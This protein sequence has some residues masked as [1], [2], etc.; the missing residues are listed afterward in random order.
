MD[1]ITHPGVF[2]KDRLMAPLGLTPDALAAKLGLPEIDLHYV[3]NGQGPMTP[4]MAEKLGEFFDMTPGFW[5]EMQSRYDVSKMPKKEI[6]SPFVGQ[7]E[8]PHGGTDLVGRQHHY[9]KLFYL[10]S[11]WPRNAL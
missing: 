9:A 3:L 2:L 5:T 6:A 1:L 8:T 7:M 10:K 11:I 4:E